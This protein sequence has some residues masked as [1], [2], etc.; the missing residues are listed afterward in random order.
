MGF[1]DLLMTLV[2]LKKYLKRK[3]VHTNEEVIKKTKLP[4]PSR[5]SL[6][7]LPSYVVND[8]ERS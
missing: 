5:G 7:F 2:K 6:I 8:E 4:S 1:F 3:K